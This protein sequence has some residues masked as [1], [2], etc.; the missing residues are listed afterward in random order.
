MRSQMVGRGDEWRLLEDC[1]RSAQA[2]RPRLVLCRGEPG[3][4][5]TR[6]AEELV[7]TAAARGFTTAWSQA[8]ESAGAPPYWPWRQVL[9]TVADQVD[10]ADIAQ[11][12]RLVTDLARLAPDVFSGPVPAMDDELSDE[13]RF[14]SFDAVARLL[15]E[16]SQARPLLI[17][18]DDAH[19]AGRS[20][21]SLL[22][23]VARS[24]TGQRLLILVNHRDTEPLPHIVSELRREPVVRQIQLR[25]LSVPA[26]A[27]QLT[28][29]L[30][31]R[32]TDAEL[33]GVHAR[34]GGNPSTSARSPGCWEIYVRRAMT[35][36]SRTACERRYRGGWPG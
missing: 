9:R 33:S 27:A 25:G 4:G 2:G 20:S 12:R 7:E 21:L 6:L 16:V 32:P 5:K 11:R 31:R 26:V 3:I 15:R 22:Q 30:G 24:M 35:F 36:P 8:A 19:D 17:V 29:L 14:R 10:L 13:T 18:L 1:L 34:T 23:H 28:G